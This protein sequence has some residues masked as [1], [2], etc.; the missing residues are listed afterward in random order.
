MDI[1]R[2]IQVKKVSWLKRL[3]FL[4][5]A[6]TFAG[7][8]LNSPSSENKLARS[9]IRVA[10]V[11]Q[12][13]LPFTISGFGKLISKHKRLLTAP[14]VATIEEVLVLPGTQVTADTIIM[15]LS[16]PDLLLQVNNAEME[17]VRHNAS[18][19]ELKV[20][21]KSEYLS[22]QANL[23]N[24]K[25]NLAAAKLKVEAQTSLAANGIV[26]AIDF[27][28]SKLTEEQFE[29]QLKIEQQR[30][31]HLKTAH[32]EKIAVQGQFAKQLEANL[33]LKLSLQAG[34]VIHA[35]IEG[36]LQ[37]LPVTLGQSVASGEQLA[38]V[39]SNKTM[40]AQLQIP[41]GEAQE[42]AIGH[43]AEINTRGALV[44]GVVNR[45]DPVITNGSVII[46]IDITQ[47]LP[48]NARPELKVEGKIEIGLLS[49]ALYVKHPV[50]V[51]ANSSQ[52]LFTLADNKQSAMQRTMKFGRIIGNN[53]EL[54]SGASTGEQFIVSDTTA[55][56]QN[57]TMII[58]D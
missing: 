13:D 11:Q 40:M 42:I 45:I 50:G 5:C 17:L 51:K 36:V 31:A 30:L 44:R 29:K 43:Q 6:L 14:T 28:R 55:Y 57:Q 54:L 20:N 4:I 35:D 48:A 34:L 21:Q 18:L 22:Y 56:L 26:S 32:Q 23:V 8:Q 41:Q 27:K 16:N 3:T 7:W 10:S 38:L 12:S 52:P 53:I 47:A 33:A 1:K 46:D 15:R 37:S 25:S 2:N 39:A 24:I 58:T 49:N 19:R 9:D